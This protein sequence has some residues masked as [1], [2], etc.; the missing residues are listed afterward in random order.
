[1]GADDKPD[2]GKPGE[3]ASKDAPG[4]EGREADPHPEAV[5]S[6]PP[7]GGGAANVPP[8]PNANLTT[9]GTPEPP[10]P[11]YLALPPPSRGISK[12]VT[13]LILTIVGS[14][15][16]LV[17]LALVAIAVPTF[18]GAR[19]RA[20][21]RATQSTLRN[22]LGAEKVYY[23]DYKRYGSAEQMQAYSV[24]QSVRFVSGDP[25][26]ASGD[27]VQEVRAALAPDGAA[28]CLVAKS[29]SGNYYAIA[30]IASGT[31]QGT[32]YLGGTETDPVASCTEDAISAGNRSGFSSPT[33]RRRPARG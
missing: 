30:D 19:S 28:V 25:A 11:Q 23:I 17:L 8:T 3:I 5:Y 32:Y 24:E 18:L 2:A 15:L 31:A 4:A 13:C 6:P 1:M 27:S 14:F 21:N 26:S 22:A 12:G 16:A 33:I 20:Q 7:A 29:A 10:Y 9:D